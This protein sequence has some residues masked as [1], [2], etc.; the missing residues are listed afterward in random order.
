MRR[1][2]L[3]RYQ[4][5]ETNL[6]FVLAEQTARAIQSVDLELQL[7]RAQVL[8]AGATT[9]AQFTAAFGQPGNGAHAA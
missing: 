7:V 2:A 1:E 8:A 9:S 6:G 3:A 4:Q 5:T